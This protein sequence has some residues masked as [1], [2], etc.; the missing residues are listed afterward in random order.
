MVNDGDAMSVEE[1]LSPGTP[2]PVGDFSGLHGFQFVGAREEPSERGG[3]DNEQRRAALA[4]E[5][6]ARAARFHQAVDSSI[7]LAS[8]GTIRWLGDSVAKLAAGDDLLTP[9]T[10]LLV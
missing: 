4:L 5:L 7:V 1:R 2:Q 3:S 10:I 8:D 9:R 6:D